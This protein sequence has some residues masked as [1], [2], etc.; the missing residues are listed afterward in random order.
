MT[1]PLTMPAET[2]ST[3][4][5]HYA[6]VRARLYGRWPVVRR[7]AHIVPEPEPEPEIGP[8]PEPAFIVT[9]VEPPPLVMLGPCSWRFLV[10][11]T[12]LRHGLQP[13]QII[14][15]SRARPVALARHEAIYLIAKHTPLS[16]LRISR[17]LR[18]NHTGLWNLPRGAGATRVWVRLPSA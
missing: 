1:P 16:L 10:A 5:Q 9:Y 15:P 2:G 17:L 18:R 12:A 8:T 6:E 14:S 13:E 3:L 11:Y 4:I 7:A